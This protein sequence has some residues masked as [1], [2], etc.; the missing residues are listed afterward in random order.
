MMN[1]PDDEEET[2]QP[3]TTISAEVAANIIT[4]YNKIEILDNSSVEDQLTA[5]LN[6]LAQ[7]KQKLQRVREWASQK[8]MLSELDARDLDKILNS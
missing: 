5:A 4:V 7:E 1:H 3:S 2:P 6:R 8:Y